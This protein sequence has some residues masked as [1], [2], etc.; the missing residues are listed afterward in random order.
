MRPLRSP[1][2]RALSLPRRR[3]DGCP[4]APW[5]CRVDQELPRLVTVHLQPWEVTR[6]PP[7][8]LQLAAHLTPQHVQVRQPALLRADPRPLDAP[9]VHQMLTAQRQRWHHRLL[10]SRSSQDRPGTSASVSTAAGSVWGQLRRHHA[11]AG[12]WASGARHRTQPR[13]R[14]SRRGRRSRC[15]RRQRR[16]TRWVSPATQRWPAPQHRCGSQ[17]RRRK[18]SRHCHTNATQT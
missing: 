10:P 13:R 1:L 6:R 14:K 16:C 8:L 7:A 12:V 17:H 4:Q 2:L 5:A 18:Q 11:A 15:T 9:Q 3:Q